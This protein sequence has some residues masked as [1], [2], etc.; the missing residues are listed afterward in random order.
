MHR[1][2]ED[3]V[4]ELVSNVLPGVQVI[5]TKHGGKT[6]DFAFANVRLD[7]L[8]QRGAHLGSIQ[9]ARMVRTGRI[10][11]VCTHLDVDDQRTRLDRFAIRCGLA[12]EVFGSEGRVEILQST[13]TDDQVRGSVCR[14]TRFHRGLVQARRT[15]RTDCGRKHNVLFG[16]ANQ[17][18]RT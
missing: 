18:V 14:N 5:K 10:G 9:C 17:K 6:D 13:Q 15:K 12:R 1:D 16:I 11:L 7:G 8:N 2:L 3:L 4:S